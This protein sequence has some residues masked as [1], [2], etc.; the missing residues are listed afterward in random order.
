M[1]HARPKL[2]GRLVGTF[3][4]YF[5]PKFIGVQLF[6]LPKGQ[7]ISKANCHSL[8]SSKKRTNEFVLISIRRVF[9][10]FFGRN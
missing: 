3:Y 1:L 2:E 9:I 5:F 7:L 10:C 8:N 6:V 4:E